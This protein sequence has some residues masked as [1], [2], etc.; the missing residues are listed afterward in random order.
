M[1]SSDNPSDLFPAPQPERSNIAARIIARSF[2]IKFLLNA[3]IAAAKRQRQPLIFYTRLAYILYS[4]V[5]TSISTVS[6][7]T[8][9]VT[10]SEMKTLSAGMV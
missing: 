7:I 5:P 3:K 2:F 8:P 10:F 4:P 6:E 9:I 1:T